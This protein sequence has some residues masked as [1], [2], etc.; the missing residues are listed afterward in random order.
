MYMRKGQ[1]KDYY[2]HHAEQMDRRNEEL[3][4]ENQKITAAMFGILK[5]KEKLKEDALAEAEAEIDKRIKEAQEE[6]AA[7][8]EAAQQD[9]EKMLNALGIDETEWERISYKY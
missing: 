1:K 7:E 4:R 3:R 8:V 6:C 5:T 9:K 2:I